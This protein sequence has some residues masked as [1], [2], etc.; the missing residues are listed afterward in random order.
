MKNVWVCIDGFLKFHPTCSMKRLP[1][2]PNTRRAV[3]AARRACSSFRCPKPS[4]KASRKVQTVLSGW[5]ILTHNQFGYPHICSGSPHWGKIGNNYITIYSA[6]TRVT[7][8]IW[9]NKITCPLPLTVQC[10]WKCNELKLVC[11]GWRVGIYTPPSPRP[12]AFSRGVRRKLGAIA[13]SGYWIS[14]GAII[15]I[16]KYHR[17]DNYK[18]RS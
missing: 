5:A 11:S 17:Q 13:S 14:S 9:H 15:N 8:S 7:K 6:S 4:H 16:W 3:A 12:V 10:I 1:Q 2:N 18:P